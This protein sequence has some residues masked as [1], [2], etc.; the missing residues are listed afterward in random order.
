[1]PRTS[2][3]PAIII[4]ARNIVLVLEQVGKLSE[5]LPR[6]CQGTLKLSM[7][8]GFL[9]NFDCSVVKLEDIIL[10]IQEAGQGQGWIWNE[11]WLNE[12]KAEMD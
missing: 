9:A 10:S 2:S 5:N 6:D 12:E 1:M 7:M 8:T 3:C 11:P 4:R